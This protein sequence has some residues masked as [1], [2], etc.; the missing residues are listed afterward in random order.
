MTARMWCTAWAL[1]A[2]LAGHA[3]AQTQVHGSA[4]VFA[5]P[6]VGLAWAIARGATESDTHV[7][8]R[9][10]SAPTIYPSLAVVGVDPFSKQ[11]K[12][13]R[14][15]AASAGTLELRIPR[16]QF[17]DFPRTEVRL[18]GGATPTVA[19]V[20]ALVVFY[21]GVPDTTPEF[22]DG[23]KL[24]TYVADR[25]ARIRATTGIPSP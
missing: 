21:L 23:A 24:A 13:W 8:L 10:V 22:T 12:V 16:A 2:I 18:Y 6:G 11:E 20:P 4:D 19:A 5:A 7:V 15:A 17:A 3:Q 25:I 1:M 9:I 14:A